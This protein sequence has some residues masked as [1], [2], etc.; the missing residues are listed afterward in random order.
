MS[1]TATPSNRRAFTLVELL[2]VIG[3]IAILMGILLPALANARE[4]GRKVKCMS[5]LRQIAMAAQMYSTSNRGWILPAAFYRNL[6]DPYGRNWT[7]T[8]ATLL[9]ANKLLPYPENVGNGFAVGNDN[10]FHCPSG[11]LE[12]ASVTT[13]GSTSVPSS[14]TDARGAMGYGHVSTGLQ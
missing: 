4:Q 1:R 9:V 6:G 11:I 14:R 7:D 2:V 8:W 5:N 3:I 10:V 13:P 12:E